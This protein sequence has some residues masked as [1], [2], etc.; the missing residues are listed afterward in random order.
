MILNVQGDK[1]TEDSGT[2]TSFYK[3]DKGFNIFV[4]GQQT[5]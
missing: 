3:Y 5:G 1:M 4:L 2:A